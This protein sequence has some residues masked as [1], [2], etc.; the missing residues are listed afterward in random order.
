MIS[1]RSAR[2]MKLS[3]SRTVFWQASTMSSFTARVR[4]PRSFTKVRVVPTSARMG[5][6]K[7][8]LSL[9]P[10]NGHAVPRPGC[11]RRKKEAIT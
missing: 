5:T 2:S 3:S 1:D 6:A 9:G 11:L 10:R 4:Q 7:P 8:S